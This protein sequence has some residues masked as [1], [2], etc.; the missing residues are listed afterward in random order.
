M[1]RKSPT[2]SHT[3]TVSLPL[4]SSYVIRRMHAVAQLLLLVDVQ[5]HAISSR[6]LARQW[7]ISFRPQRATG[8]LVD[9]DTRQRK[10]LSEGKCRLGHQDEVRRGSQGNRR[11]LSLARDSGTGEGGRYLGPQEGGG[12]PNTTPK[13]RDGPCAQSKAETKPQRPLFSLHWAFLARRGGSIG[14]NGDGPSA[15]PGGGPFGA[16][17]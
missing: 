5:D 4:P 8:S 6:F 13:C 2:H 10:G 11:A 9:A 7:E 1:H 3:H 14:W 15:C 12:G 17:K 16:A